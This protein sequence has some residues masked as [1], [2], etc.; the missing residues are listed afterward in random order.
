M[1][2]DSWRE[3]HVKVSSHGKGVVLESEGL[4]WVLNHEAFQLYFSKLLRECN[5]D[6]SKKI[7]DIKYNFP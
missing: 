3:K 2:F 4:A 5:E 1:S 6:I 7:L